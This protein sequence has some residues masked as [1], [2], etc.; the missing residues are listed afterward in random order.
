[1][2]IHTRK[3]ATSFIRGAPDAGA[4]AAGVRKGRKRQI[5]HTIFDE[6]LGW[7]DEKAA[8]TGVSRAAIIN[9]ALFQM[10]EA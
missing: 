5:T 7:V 4:D 3:S 2:A 10:R 6:M 9:T 1:M 8:R